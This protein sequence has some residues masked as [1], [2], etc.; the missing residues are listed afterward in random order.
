MKIDAKVTFKGQ[1]KNDMQVQTTSVPIDLDYVECNEDD[2]IEWIRQHLEN[3]C[4]CP[5]MNEDFTVENMEDIMRELAILEYN[6][7]DN[8][9]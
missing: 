2:V 9:F 7:N 3:N 6:N 1:L 5:V 8:S 4:H